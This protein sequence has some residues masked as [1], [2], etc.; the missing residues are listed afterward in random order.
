M[1]GWSSGL[2][3]LCLMF[4]TIEAN[5]LVSN[6]AGPSAQFGAMAVLSPGAADTVCFHETAKQV[7]VSGLLRSATVR[8]PVSPFC[9]ALIVS[10]ESTAKS[11]SKAA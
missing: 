11:R 6:I 3:S 2:A 8:I 7:S 5:C 9:S 1:A 10:Q 4:K